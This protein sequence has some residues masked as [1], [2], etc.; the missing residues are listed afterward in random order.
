M[1][2]VKQRL[3]E[4]EWAYGA[5]DL[6]ARRELADR[7]IATGRDEKL[8]TYS[9]LVRGVTFRLPNVNQGRPFEIDVSDWSDLHRAII[10]DF[11][12]CI[13]AESYVTAGIFLSA[14]VVTKDDGTPG[15]GFTN[16]MRDLGVLAGSSQTAALECW[17]REVQ[18]VYE[19]CQKSKPGP[20]G[21]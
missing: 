16:F 19:W 1:D 7:I 6:R 21:T 11:L 18:K 14:I 9:G 2:E 4:Y 13:S 12:G 8:I 3:A 20:A 5:K 15:P 17:V 10:G